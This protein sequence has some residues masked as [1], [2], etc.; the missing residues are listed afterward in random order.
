MPGELN[1][2][3]LYAFADN[4]ISFVKE[5]LELMDKNIP[6]DLDSIEKALDSNDLALVTRN[7]HHMKSSVQY[8]DYV[9]LSDFLSEIETK[10]DSPT[11]IAEIKGMMPQLKKLLDNLVQLIQAEMK[12]LA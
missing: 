2:N 12:K 5:I 1:L 6:T 3:Y 9:E 10:K 4:D 11:A 7:A 8:I